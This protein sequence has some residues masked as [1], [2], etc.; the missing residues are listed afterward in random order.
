MYQARIHRFLEKTKKKKKSTAVNKAEGKSNKDET[1]KK[2]EG[3]F[4]PMIDG[5]EKPTKEQEKLRNKVTKLM[6]KQKVHQV[7]R[8]LKE[9]D[10][11]EPW[12]QE[13][14]VKVCDV[15]SCKCGNH[16]VTVVIIPCCCIFQV[17]C[18]L[19]Q[20]LTE[21]AY[22]QPPIDQLGDGPPEIRPAF[23]HSLKTLTK[24]TQ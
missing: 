13:A 12:G 15:Y 9:Q 7:R 21:T 8:I 10:D 2:P 20:L 5:Q 1:D 23:L 6:K 17:G 22:I 4:D 24:E 14:Q 18:R 16:I 3:E 19:I 11:V